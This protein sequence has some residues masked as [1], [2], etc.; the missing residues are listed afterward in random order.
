MKKKFIKMLK[1]LK[2]LQIKYFICGDIYL[3]DH[4]SWI[5]EKCKRFGIKL[6]EPFYGVKERISL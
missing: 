4:P 2:S 3:R 5:K 6:V 1:K